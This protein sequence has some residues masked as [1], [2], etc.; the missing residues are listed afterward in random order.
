MAY[1]HEHYRVEFIEN[2]LQQDKIM[3]KGQCIGNHGTIS[4]LIKILCIFKIYYSI[5]VD[6]NL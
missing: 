1:K 4:F 3:N 5:L 6:G 2:L